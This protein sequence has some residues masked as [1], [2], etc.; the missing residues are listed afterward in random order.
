MSKNKSKTITK[1]E[2]TKA[3]TAPAE[4]PK[5][6]SKEAATKALV[7]DE[8]K[9]TLAEKATAALAGQEITYTVQ[10]G[11]T[12]NKIARTYSTTAA[13]IGTLNSIANLN[14]IEVNQVLKVKVGDKPAKRVSGKPAT[15]P[16]TVTNEKGEIPGFEVVRGKISVEEIEALAAEVAK[17][18]EMEV[19]LSDVPEIT[20]DMTFEPETE[21]GE[22]EAADLAEQGVEVEYA[23]GL[24]PN[25]TKADL[26]EALQK[27]GDSRATSTL[28]KKSVDTLEGLLIEARKANAA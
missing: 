17:E 4:A 15:Q 21:V 12:L 24:G 27:A 2:A 5:P 7:T 16:V 23:D 3:L 8:A 28:M 1:A 14:K 26:V 10:K 9:A 25:R 11:D 22:K 18:A 6:V 19:D 20:E 13:A